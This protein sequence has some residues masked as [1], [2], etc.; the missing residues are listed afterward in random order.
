MSDIDRGRWLE[1]CGAGRG[2]QVLLGPCGHKTDLHRAMRKRSPGVSRSALALC[3]MGSLP[4]AGAMALSQTAQTPVPAV[5]QQSVS[6]SGSGSPQGAAAHSIPAALPSAK[7]LA[8]VLY[9]QKSLTIVADN[10]NL[11]K[12]LGQIHATVGVPFEGSVAN[13]QNLTGKFGPGVARDVIESLLRKAGY[14]Y[15][16]VGDGSRDSLTSVVIAGKDKKA[17]EAANGSQGTGN[18][19]SSGAE[20]GA[21]TGAA[22]ASSGDAGTGTPTQPAAADAALQDPPPATVLVPSPDG[23]PYMG[24]NPNASTVQQSHAQLRTMMQQQSQQPTPPQ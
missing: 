14:N 18:A 19:S 2:R 9:R 5:A 23:S 4:F 24:G 17:D 8:Q 11:A 7:N 3:L 21:A 15:I 13:D 10:S 20:S 16:L 1:G 12:V 6:P 22:G